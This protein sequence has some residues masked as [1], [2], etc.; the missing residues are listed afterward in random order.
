MLHLTFMRCE[1]GS[2][3]TW[4]YLFPPPT[5]S[6]KSRESQICKCCRALPA[7]FSDPACTPRAP[8]NDPPH[9]SL[10]AVS[11]CN[12]RSMLYDARCFTHDSLERRRAVSTASRPR[13]QQ[14][15]AH[16]GKLHMQPT[17]ARSLTNWARTGASTPNASGMIVNS[18]L[19]CCS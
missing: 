8:I 14:D 13:I 5:K 17:S 2:N 11:S 1:V 19:D 10:E 6:I 16:H 12:V 3:R 4:Q 7:L 9:V 18:P 15:A